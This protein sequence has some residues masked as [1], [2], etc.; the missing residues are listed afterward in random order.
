MTDRT[1]KSKVDKLQK[2]NA[3][4]ARLQDQADKLKADIQTEMQARAVDEVRAGDSVVRWKPI[5]TSRFDGKAFKQAHSALYEQFL[6]PSI[7][8]RFTVVS[9]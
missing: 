8:R 9:A 5:V 6:T 4:I 2:V 1:L 7:T 3:E